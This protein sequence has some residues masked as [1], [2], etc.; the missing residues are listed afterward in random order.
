MRLP[1]TEPKILL[2]VGA[3]ML[4]MGFILPLL[5]T[6]QVIPST[7]FLNFLSFGFQLV[8]MVLSTIGSF[9]IVKVRMDK[10]KANNKNNHF[11]KENPQTKKW[12]GK[13]KK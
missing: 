7:Y 13:R 8:G 9:S 2:W 5:M 6:S 1:K 12:F 11:V 4:V 10:E 3:A